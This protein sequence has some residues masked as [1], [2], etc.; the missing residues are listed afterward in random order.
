[1]RIEDRGSV[2]WDRPPRIQL[3]VVCSASGAAFVDGGRT[4]WVQS[5]TRELR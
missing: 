1:M 2:M 3:A 4:T 5:E